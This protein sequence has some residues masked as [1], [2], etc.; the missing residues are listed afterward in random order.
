MPWYRV[1]LTVAE[2]EVVIAE[3]EFHSLIEVPEPDGLLSVALVRPRRPAD[4]E[5]R[6]SD[7]RLL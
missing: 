3:R 1:Q 7:G 5:W 2:Q 4:S 6:R